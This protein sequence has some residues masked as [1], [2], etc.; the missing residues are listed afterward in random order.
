MNPSIFKKLHLNDD[1][2]SSNVMNKIE[3][4]ILDLS[5]DKTVEK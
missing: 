2:C 3:K 1:K 4:T 5:I